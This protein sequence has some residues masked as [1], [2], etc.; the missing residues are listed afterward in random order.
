MMNVLINCSK[1]KN[2]TRIASVHKENESCV[3][4]TL[5]G[6]ET[7]FALL[8]NLFVCEGIPG[9][10]LKVHA[11]KRTGKKDFISTMQ[12]AL[13]EHYQDQLVGKI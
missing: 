10:V 13:A 2:G 7:R 9:K 5:K 11:K 3:L 4:E 12:Q 8:A 6:N 1:I